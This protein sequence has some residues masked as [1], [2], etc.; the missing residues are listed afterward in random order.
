AARAHAASAMP[1]R[2]GVATST[3]DGP[4]PSVV[5]PVTA[6]APVTTPAPVPAPAPA[7]VASPAPDRSREAYDTFWNG[8]KARD[9]DA[10]F[11][12]YGQTCRLEVSG[13]D[14]A[15]GDN[16]VRTALNDFIHAFSGGEWT[17]EHVT[18]GED[19]LVAELTWSGPAVRE[20]AGFPATNRP[21]TMKTLHSLRFDPSGAVVHH[22]IY[23]E[24]FK[25]AESTGLLPDLRTGWGR[26]CLALVK[27]LTALGRLFSR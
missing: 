7:P 14:V 24:Q 5:A 12:A 9:T 10:V 11:K 19:S 3:L 16:A 13:C 18:V 21:M 8:F 17:E 22:S 23:L 2:S 26:F 27:P 20:F 15:E 4:P 6:P 25:W 1:R